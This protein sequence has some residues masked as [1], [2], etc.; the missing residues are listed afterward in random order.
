MKKLDAD[1]IT[2]QVWCGA[3]LEVTDILALPVYAIKRVVNLE[4]YENYPPSALRQSGI[5]FVHIP[6]L[7]IDHPLA[8][9][10]IDKLV[11]AIDEVAARGEG[12]YVHC[13]AG[14]QRSP[15]AVAC[16]LVHTGM[17]A[18]QALALVKEKRPVVRF[19]PA[20][21]ASVFKYA[22]RLRVRRAAEQLS[23]K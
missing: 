8:D 23:K 15:A 9:K 22:S 13:T 14:W 6:V 4:T 20:H 17:D 5:D 21:I 1:R 18:E 10:T 3:T 2:E 7:D 11:A 19:Y 16:Y 12:V